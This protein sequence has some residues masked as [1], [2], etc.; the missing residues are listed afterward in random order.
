MMQVHLS[1]KI[2]N[3]DENQNSDESP[4]KILHLLKLKNANRLAHLMDGFIP[5]HSMDK[6]ANTGDIGFYIREDIPS[7]QISF[8][9]KDDDN[10]IE[11][12]FAEMNLQQK[13]GY[14]HVHI[15]LTSSS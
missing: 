8:K 5:P 2:H 6:T 10:D 1:L 13:S 3:S 12:S 9:D 11:H 7:R 14:I 4:D 15:T